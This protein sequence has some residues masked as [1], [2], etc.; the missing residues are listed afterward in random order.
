[1]TLNAR[2]YLPNISDPSLVWDVR[3]CGRGSSDPP[4]TLTCN[5]LVALLAQ[6]LHFPTNTRRVSAAFVTRLVEVTGNVDIL[7]LNT[8]WHAHQS[9]ISTV[10]CCKGK[11]R[12]ALTIDLLD[13]FFL[14]LDDYPISDP[15]SEDRRVLSDI[16][17][18]VDL[19]CR[20]L[21]LHSSWTST[22]NIDILFRTAKDLFVPIAPDAGVTQD[23]GFQGGLESILRFIRTLLP[24]VQS[25]PPNTTTA[26]QTVVQSN[27]DFYLPFRELAP[28]RLIAKSPIGPFSPL[29][30]SSPGAFGS[31]VIF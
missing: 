30:A 22:A 24:I 13:P 26:L 21:Q 19:C 31:A 25:N 29:N 12:T 17:Q 2:D 14:T 5:E 7:L 9:V 6:W 16:S 28:S 27:L 11:K 20:R 8:V 4:V 15:S 3:R 10:L 18:A 23:Y 1:M